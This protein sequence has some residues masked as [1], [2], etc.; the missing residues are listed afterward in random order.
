MKG[1]LRLVLG[2]G[3]LGLGVTMAGC[4]GSGSSA[5]TPSKAAATPAF[6]PAA[7]MF[8]SAQSVTI[9]D[10]TAGASIYYTTNGT[11]PTTS[12]TFYTGA[13]PV[14]NTLTINAIATASGYAASPVA[15][16][17]F[18][19]NIPTVATATPMFS[20]APGSYTSSQSVTLAD[21]TASATIYYT[22]DG[23]A[24][25]TSS[26]QYTGAITVSSTTT[27][28]AIAVASGYLP[29]AVA[30]GK[31]TISSMPVAAT[32]TFS[33]AAGT[34]TSA[35]TVAIS[36]TTAGATIYYTT[37]GSAP[38]A[39]STVY[40]S[41][42]PVA[43]TTTINAIAVASGYTNSA[44]G[45]AAYTINLPAAPGPSYTYKNVAIVGGGFVD[46]VF[47]HPKSQGL[48]YARTDVGGA[49]R[50]N[51]VTGGDTQWVPLLDFVGRYQSGFNLGVESLAIDPN[52]ATRLYIATGEY[53][54]SGDQDYIFVSGDMGN[55]F[56]PV[57][58]PFAN[59]S[60]NNGRFAG[61]RL[62]VDPSNGKHIYFGTRQNGLYESNDQGSTWAQ[63]A[64]F[65][66]KAGTGTS[67]DPGVGII[68][69]NF[70]ANSGTASN[71][72][73]KT[74]YYGVS[75]PTTNPAT[76]QST[77]ATGLY[78]SN[79]GGQTFTAVSNQPTGFYLNSGVFDPSNTYLYLS[80]ARQ[81]NVTAYQVSTPCTSN[82]TSV[83]PNGVNDGQIWRYTLPTTSSP[84][85]SWTNITP[86]LLNGES[87]SA[88]V[89]NPYGFSGVS[90]DPSNPSTV[91]V[92]TLNKYYPP[93]FDDIFR[94]LNNGQTWVDF[95]SNATL[96]DSNAPWLS[97]GGKSPAAPNW[98]NHAVVDPFNPK[99]ILYGE[100]YGVWQTGLGQHGR[101]H[102]RR[103]QLDVWLPGD[104][105]N[106][107]PGPREPALR[108]G[109]P[110]QRNV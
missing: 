64:A 59:G 47:F 105:R 98:I 83:G 46:G 44:V 84:T 43:S 9:T 36:D 67:F 24:P 65:P 86:P 3:V 72:N 31:Y 100:G 21:S 66:V 6:S 95:Q 20:P 8:T 54:T 35:Q 42:I 99:H 30:T 79:D 85:G 37:N 109:A 106:R 12:S 58:L 103:D 81:A 16:A 102:W 107:A 29:S 80:Y 78:V 108:T 56:N 2:L 87:N 50:W 23:S 11:T 94:S 73:T 28:N 26:T 62:S 41:A 10:S 13:I 32:P 5:G 101:R 77:G 14:S 57:K 68:F 53:V 25:S 75:D 7:G 19:I 22:T 40:S 52:D 63:V 33:P 61:E 18:T 48:M 88:Y 110:V 92:T 74:I 34:Y 49:Y 93:P 97:F 70:L 27:L 82:C 39:S 91:M 38:S 4:G 90:I 15:T 51:N 89:S 17:T 104:R 1:V 96:N 69:E 76:S 60:N 71:G 55:T 45:T